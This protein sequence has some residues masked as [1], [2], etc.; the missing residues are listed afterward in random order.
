MAVEVNQLPSPCKHIPTQTLTF[1]SNEKGAEN[2]ISENAICKS[3]PATSGVNSQ[4]LQL[5]KQEIAPPS[6]E[7]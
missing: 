1:N 4:D 3:D 2:N 7:S 6:S 5:I